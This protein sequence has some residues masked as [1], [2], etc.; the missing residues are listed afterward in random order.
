MIIIRPVYL[1]VENMSNASGF[2]SRAGHEAWESWVRAGVGAQTPQEQEATETMHADSTSWV[3]DYLVTIC[4]EEFV[5]DYVWTPKKQETAEYCA[6]VCLRRGW[7]LLTRS[8]SADPP[9][10][11]R[12][13][14]TSR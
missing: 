7:N 6:I 8:D 13:S 3:L 12:C 9:G 5:F 2:W 10:C 1:M 11:Y 14:C 4:L